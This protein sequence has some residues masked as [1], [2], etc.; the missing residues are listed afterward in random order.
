[1]I[2]HFFRIQ[3]V[4]RLLL[5]VLLEQCFVCLPEICSE[6]LGTMLDHLYKKKSA[7]ETWVCRYD[8]ETKRQS[9]TEKPEVSK[10][11]KRAHV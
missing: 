9:P 1:M 3:L 7:D 8:P 10:T 4:L 11:E 2:Q 5:S 6:L